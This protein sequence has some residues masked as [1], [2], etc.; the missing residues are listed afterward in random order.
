M[1]TRLIVFLILTSSFIL[2]ARA[3]SATWNLN[4]TSN[5]WSSS[6]NWTPAT[7]PNGPDDIA[8]FGVSNETELSVGSVLEVDSIVFDPGASAYSLAM[9][10]TGGPF[11]PSFTFSGAGLINNSGVVQSFTSVAAGGYNTDIFFTNSATAGDLTSFVTDGGV[12]SESVGATIQFLDNSNAGSATFTNKDS[13]YGSGGT[14]E[15]FD[16]SS[17][18]TG[19][20]TCEGGEFPFYFF[21]GDVVFNDLSTAADGTFIAEGGQANNASGGGITFFSG[22]PTAADATLIAEGGTN[23]GDGGR[24]AFYATSDG[25]RARVEVS[26]N[27]ILDIGVHD[28]PSLTIGSL[29]GDGLVSLVSNSLTVGRNNLDTSFDGLI[30]GTGYL[31]KIGRGTLTLTGANTYT[32]RTVVK[33]G[34]LSIRDRTGGLTVIA[35]SVEV[36]GGTF[37]GSGLVGGAA[38]ITGNRHSTLEANQLHGGNFIFGKGLT[39]NSGAT[40]QVD[41]NSANGGR[42]SD[43]R[44]N[45]VTINPGAVFAIKDSGNGVF[46]PSLLPIIINNSSA[47]IA[48]EFSNLPDGGSI[49]VGQ[50]TYVALYNVGDGNDL[51][52]LV[53]Q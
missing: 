45:G 46:A 23:R 24:I 9:V 3:G 22:S 7:V 21:G 50:N 43:V 29:E 53:N 38:V 10:Y 8:T 4:P 52:L 16:N 48:G 47:P 14:I 1:N 18:G 26:G 5:A 39:F 32:G 25:G 41:V 33:Q 42:Y 27:G 2:D 13:S 17:A 19:T 31:T 34:A 49:T 40:Y 11:G 36:D 37:G 15:F 20:F 30:S 6:A 12:P 35:G 51:Y 28:S 44:A